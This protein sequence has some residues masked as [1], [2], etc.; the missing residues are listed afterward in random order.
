MLSED[1]FY[2]R[3]NVDQKKNFND[4]CF[5][6]IFVFRYNPKDLS[7]F[8]PNVILADRPIRQ[9]SRFHGFIDDVLQ[10]VPEFGEN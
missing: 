8:H 2:I 1:S 5:C 6:R 10:S 9:K 7:I 4:C 3:N